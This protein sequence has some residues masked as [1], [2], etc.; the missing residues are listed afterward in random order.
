MLDQFHLYYGDAFKSISDEYLSQL[1]TQ[2]GGN[3]A[4]TAAHLGM[5]LNNSQAIAAANNAAALGKAPP[6][7]AIQSVPVSE[8]ET[9]PFIG[10]FWG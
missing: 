5:I 7:V 9:V 6:T 1:L 8:A 4:K 2:Y 10:L 3:Y